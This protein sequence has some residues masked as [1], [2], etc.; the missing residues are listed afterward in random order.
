MT[1]FKTRFNKIGYKIRI[2]PIGIKTFL[3]KYFPFRIISKYYLRSIITWKISKK[4]PINL[5]IG[6]GGLKYPNWVSTDKFL[7]DITHHQEWDF[8]FMQGS[9]DR[10]LA[11][12]LVEHLTVGDLTK[13][14][15]YISF[16]LKPDGILR[17]AVPDGY[18]PD[19]DYINRVKPDGYGSGS[20][21]HKFLYTYEDL[22]RILTDCGFDVTLLEYYDENGLFHF[23]EWNPDDGMIVRSIRFDE[24]N[25]MGEIRYTSLIVDAYKKED[26]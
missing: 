8:Y 3:V 26:K 2:I 17:I 16:F 11:E 9:I 12:H 10:I 13:A 4:N 19:P 22:G 23:N 15:K 18:F 21:D 7:L 6:A 5:I 14:L 25:Q 1:V 24:R 20:K